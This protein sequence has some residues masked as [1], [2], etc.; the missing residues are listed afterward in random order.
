MQAIKTFY[1]NPTNTKSGRIKA[2]CSRGSL[3]IPY[4]HD[5]PLGERGAFAANALLNKFVAADKKRG[6]PEAGNPWNRK[7]VTGELADG[8]EVHVFITGK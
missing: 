5:V 1:L 6:I 2:T 7:F 4:P 8:A 3:T